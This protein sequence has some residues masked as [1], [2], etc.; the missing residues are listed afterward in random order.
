MIDVVCL[1]PAMDRT[2]WIPALQAGA[3]N[4]SKD[5]VVMPGG[6]GMNV[7]RFIKALD[8]SMAVR[9]VG[10]VGG[11]TGQYI[12]DGCARL[13][14]EESFVRIQEGTRVC[15][16]VVE[17]TRCTVVNEDGPHVDGEELQ[18]FRETLVGKPDLALISGSAPAGVP[19]YLYQ[20]IVQSYKER[21]VPVYVDTSGEH[22]Q[23]ALKAVPTIVKV[24]EQ[25]FAELVSDKVTLN[26]H[27]LIAYAN[28]LLQAGVQ[29]VIITQGDKGSV[30]IT[31][32][33]VANVPVPAVTVV[34]SIACGDAY[35]AGMAVG[36][37]HRL[38]ILESTML[39]TAAAAMKIES[40]APMIEH[41][42][43]LDAYYEN[44]KQ[45]YAKRGA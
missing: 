29:A 27:Q 14:I 40:L 1:N 28:D 34:N 13:A 18:Q 24:N 10:F 37:M 38:S 21:D 32:E 33:V 31:K 11:F 45:A 8:D 20:E 44:V 17:D 42:Q 7:A 4:R 39:G 36:M 16:I 12:V 5:L 2:L 19:S 6:K 43:R 3:I 26:Q 22:L 23:A 15:T 41:P 9:V 35:F 25:E 30:V